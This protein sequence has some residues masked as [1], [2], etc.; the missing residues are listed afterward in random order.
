MRHKIVVSFLRLSFM[1]LP[2]EVML[3]SELGREYASRYL[4]DSAAAT[5][6]HAVVIFDEMMRL[7]YYKIYMR[8]QHP[9]D[10]NFNHEW[11]HQTVPS[12]PIWEKSS[13]PLASFLEANHLAIT[14]ELLALDEDGQLERLHFRSIR[15]EGQDWAPESG[16]R[17]V[18]LMTADVELPRWSTE[19]G[20]E[21]NV[22]THKEVC[23]GSFVL[24]RQCVA[25]RT[26]WSKLPRALVRA[27]C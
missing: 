10:M 4:T 5:L 19:A 6:E 3:W 16:Y 23:S 8:W 12:D 2:A 20:D 26:V 24:F 11:F 9:Y 21:R 25:L 17:V 1:K 14:S 15:A 13:V 18:E 7:P 22:E 27:A